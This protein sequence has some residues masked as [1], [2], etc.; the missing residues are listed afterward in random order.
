MGKAGLH[1]YGDLLPFIADQDRDVA[2]HAVAGFGVDTPAEVVD[3]LIADLVAGDPQR[4]PA[5]SEALRVIGS[6]LVLR[7]LIAAQRGRNSA[8][9]WLLATIGRLPAAKVRAALA[10]DALL[11]RLAPMLLLSDGASWMAN[12]AVDVD[13]KF[14]LKQNI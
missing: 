14:L 4:A 11:R 2:L 6:D 13:L 5:A 8:D 9:A 10:G 7:Q 1:Q 3:H 12:D